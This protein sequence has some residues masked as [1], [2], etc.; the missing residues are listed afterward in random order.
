MP[1]ELLENEPLSRHT[2]FAIG[3]P[4]TFF[5]RA[6]SKEDLLAAATYVRQK[7]LPYTI[8]GGGSNVL[9][10]DRGFDGVVIKN[11]DRSYSIEG[12][13]VRA[14]SG[15]VLASLVHA[16]SEQGLSGLEW[17]FGVP[18]TVGGA[19]R[20]NAGAFGGE[21]KDILE[22][23]EI[24]DM[25]T[26]EVK[27]V[28]QK[29]MG[30][31]YR[32]SACADHPEWLILQATLQLT[33][34][35]PISTR[36]KVQEFLAQKKET[37]PLGAHCAGSMFK[38]NPIHLF[39]DTSSLPQEYVQKGRVPSGYLIEMAGLKGYHTDRIMISDK[40]ANFFINTGGAT[41]EDVVQLVGL[42]KK[43]VFEKYGIHLSEEIHYIG[44]LKK[45]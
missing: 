14:S 26:G 44:F 6:R 36:K 35:D 39:A 17:A 24:V 13:C 2:S 19:V 23:V 33:K 29:D 42:A 10:S 25:I 34:S 1:F 21:T 11:E 5:I 30:F 31:T 18:G 22:S 32:R 16:T 8:L 7:R 41:S 20:G 12:A 3:G 43:R 27:T 4:A 38:N 28:L 45:S 37:Q 15:V 40:H 9:V